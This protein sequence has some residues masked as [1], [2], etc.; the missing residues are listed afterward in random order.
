MNLMPWRKPKSA[1]QKSNAEWGPS[2]FG[3][4]MDEFMDRW[5]QN[6]WSLL[7]GEPSWTGEGWDPAFEITDGER[8]VTVRAEVP[9]VA[10]EDLKVTL[11]GRV[12][13]VSGEKKSSRE[14]KGTSL[15]RSECTYGS[16]ERSV[17]LPDTV[18]PEKISAEHRNGIL[19]IRFEKVKTADARRI[20]VEM[21]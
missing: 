19:T 6:P 12:L 20:P 16:F 17:E 13:T 2:V 1:V 4:D 8:E 15:Y 3:R 11:T 10:P 7:G 14:E 18:N 5:F 21:K 9:G